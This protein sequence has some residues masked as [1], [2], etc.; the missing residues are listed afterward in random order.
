MII[1]ADSLQ[2]YEDLPI[3]TARPTAEEEA[4]APHRLFGFLPADQKMDV[5]RWLGLA[6]A[7]AAEVQGAGQV[8]IFCGGTG[9]YLKALSEGLSPIPQVAT[10]EAERAWQKSA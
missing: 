1:N 7:T 8:P 2:V 3:L 6:R 5:A 9:F 4:Q 10:Q